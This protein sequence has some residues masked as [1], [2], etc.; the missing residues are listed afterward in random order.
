MK[1]SLKMKG[2]YGK[3]IWVLT[4]KQFLSTKRKTWKPMTNEKDIVRLY[5]STNDMQKYM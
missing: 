5:A 1:T 4:I 2:V 3:T